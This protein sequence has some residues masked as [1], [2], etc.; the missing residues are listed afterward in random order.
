MLEMLLLILQC[1]AEVLADGSALHLRPSES[2]S[3]EK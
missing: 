1:I 3:D 2:S